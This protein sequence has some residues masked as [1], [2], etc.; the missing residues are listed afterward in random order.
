[1]AWLK[2]LNLN[3]FDLHC[4][5]YLFNLMLHPPFRRMWLPLISTPYLPLT[6]WYFT[7]CC[8]VLRHSLLC[9]P[10]T[11]SNSAS[12]P[13]LCREPW[14]ISAGQY[15][16]RGHLFFFFN[17]NFLKFCPWNSMCYSDHPEEILVSLVVQRVK[18]L[19]AIQENW[20]WSPGQEDPPGEENGNPLQHSC[21]ENAKDRGA[22]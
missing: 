3:L 18:C 12:H 8:L 7:F 10:Q 21:Q 11:S 2:L 19:P 15:R 9:G 13:T 16:P 4:W 20:V 22:W 6:F 5:I 1:M 14:S 17:S